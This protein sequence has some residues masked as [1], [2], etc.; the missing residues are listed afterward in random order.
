MQSREKANLDYLKTG[1]M[2]GLVLDHLNAMLYENNTRSNP[3]IHNSLDLISKF[4]EV[5][6]Q[7]SKFKNENHY[8]SSYVYDRTSRFLID[9]ARKYK[10]EFWT[11]IH[12][13]Q[14]SLCIEA[15]ETYTPP[16]K[17]VVSKETVSKP[18]TAKSEPKLE[19]SGDVSY[20]VDSVPP[21]VALETVSQDP[22]VQVLDPDNPVETPVDGDLV[23]PGPNPTEVQS[24]PSDGASGTTQPTSGNGGNEEVRPESQ[25][26]LAW[27]WSIWNHPVI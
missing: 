22:P 23:Q 10:S 7:V 12:E 3:Q 14:R 27:F 18:P 8:P 21:T 11:F 25:S 6:N 1:D 5:I 15:Y 26:W 4:E 16:A 13:N 19:N 24:E 9:A 17:S 2:K 20:P